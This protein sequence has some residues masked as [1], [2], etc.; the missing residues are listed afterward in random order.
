[1]AWVCGMPCRRR[2]VITKI[3]LEVLVMSK[4]ICRD[5]IML[6]TL[7]VVTGREEFQQFRIYIC[8]LIDARL[9][10]ECRMVQSSFYGTEMSQRKRTLITR[11]GP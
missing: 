9:D 7:T 1:M 8:P 5:V 10:G 4:D 11:Q 6:Y 3:L 2:R